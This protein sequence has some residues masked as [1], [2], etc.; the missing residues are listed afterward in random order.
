MGR[1]L[2]VGIDLG[3]TKALGVVID[4]AADAPPLLVERVPTPAGTGAVVEALVG[5]AGKL[6]DRVDAELADRVAAIGIGLP[7]LVDR[8][9]VLRFAPNL[10]GV[11][12]CDVAGPVGAGTGVPT[13]V[14]NDASAA[15]WAEQQRGVAVGHDDVLLVTLGTGIGAGVVI[16]GKPLG[17]A[18]GFAG[19][20]GHMVVKPDG[21][22]CPCG[23]RGCWERF[24]SGSGL[25]RLAREAAH[26]GRST[27]VVA[28]AGGDPEDVRGEHA[29]QAAAEGD[30]EAR[31]VLAGF[32]W[33]LALGV[34][35]LVNVLDPEVVV[36]G[37]GLAEA[38]ELVLAPTRRAYGELVFASGHRPE[39]PIVAAA[40]GEQ[41][42][43]V[44][45][46]LLAA[47]GAQ[48]RWRA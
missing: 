6:A 37:G 23:R 15:V 42:G 45:A 28:L 7:G 12:E 2:V 38:G 9:G 35:N 30:A 5:L 16:R 29:S 41:A 44:G 21:P 39:V 34:A 17:G 43:A 20:P 31:E 14:A 33:W 40:L 26:A 18:H 8:S 36:M 32:G 47:P 19:E 10:P 25:G 27:R 1:E 13:V 4:A 24:A 48:P 11:T 22:L 3:G 46:A